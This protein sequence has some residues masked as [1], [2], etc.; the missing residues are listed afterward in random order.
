MLTVA[1]G[2]DRAAA[3]AQ[4]HRR[5]TSPGMGGSQ[6]VPPTPVGERALC[7]TDRATTNTENQDHNFD[8]MKEYFLKS[9]FFLSKYYDG[10]KF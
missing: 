9:D 6:S 4:S 10:T 8:L 1:A 5:D 7:W 3:A 2:S